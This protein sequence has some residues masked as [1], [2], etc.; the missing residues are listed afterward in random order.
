MVIL[1]GLFIPFS[2]TNELRC[3]KHFLPK[4]F[5]GKVTIYFNKEKG[6]QEFDGEGCVVY[7]I[8][9]GGEYFSSLPLKEGISYPGKTFKF[10]ESVDKDSLIEIPEFDK[11]EYLLDSVSNK[12]KKYVSITA[13]GY[14]NTTNSGPSYIFE[15][16]VD[17][18][19]K[20]FVD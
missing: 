12:T 11:F 17:Y 7:R 5:L 2:C 4:G 3:E 10:Y 16:Y 19:N 1:F 9:K 15:Y 14:V 20:L 13:S 18:G 6:Q 8:S